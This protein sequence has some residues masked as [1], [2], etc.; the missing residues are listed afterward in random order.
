MSLSKNLRVLAALGTVSGAL[1]AGT[2]ATFTDD[3]TASSTFTAGTLDLVAGGDADDAHAFTALDMANMKPG[4][5]KYAALTVAN[6]GSLGFTYDLTTSASGTTGIQDELQ[7]GA[8]TVANTGAC[9][10]T[11]YTGAV[12][13]TVI[14]EG[15]LSAAAIDDRALASGSEVLCFKVELPQA[16]G[17]DFQ[18]DA[19]TATFTLTATQS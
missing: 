10:S 7:L 19:T 4:D 15:D 17:N 1:W 8:R 11:G 14:S 6:A 3:A 16:T 12:L 5:V 18:G 9:T 13:S 2:F